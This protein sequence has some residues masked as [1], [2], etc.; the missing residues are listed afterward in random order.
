MTSRLCLS[1]F[2]LFTLILSLCLPVYA[3]L[4]PANNAD[5]NVAPAPT[6]G[7]VPVPAPGATAQPIVPTPTPDPEK[8]G[9]VEALQLLRSGKNDDAMTRVNAIIQAD[10]KFVDAYLLRGN[11]YAQKLQWTEAGK[12][13]E[14]A[15]GINP[16]NVTAKF[17]LAETKFR[18]KLYDEARTIFASVGGD[19]DNGDLAS[20]K[21]F[22]CDLF[23][24][25]EDVAA[26]ELDV[27]NQVGSHASYYFSNIAW[28][29][30]HK[31]IEDAR[32][33]LNSANQIYNPNK[34]IIYSVSL[35]DLGYLPLPPPPQA[36]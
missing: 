26:K 33:W 19:P 34:V 13:Y 1:P 14:T 10:P 8:Q 25:H 36:Q 15:L 18:M 24:G 27:F 30:Y 2:C 29:L 20:Y 21:V 23:G 3:Q 28:D 5:K 9:I 35:K 7:S 32:G 6:S 31:K 16:N 11:I 4:P 22:L 12:E 17:N